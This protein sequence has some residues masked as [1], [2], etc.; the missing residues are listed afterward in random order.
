MSDSSLLE[1]L[2]SLPKVR[3]VLTSSG[4]LMH[5]P[6]YGATA[7]QTQ[8]SY[9]RRSTH[10]GVVT[11]VLSLILLVLLWGDV[12]TF[13]AGERTIQFKVYD[14]IDEYMQLNL[15]MTVNMPC[16]CAYALTVTQVNIRDAAG[17][18]EM[19]TDA[20]IAKDGTFF[21]VHKEHKVE[22]VSAD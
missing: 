5:F 10:G 13:L 4:S 6:R 3:R 1:R 16:Q 22:C 20:D 2:D 12:Y 8:S 7:Y 14:R 21:A 17:D 11:V 19:V 15:D 18:R 9:Q